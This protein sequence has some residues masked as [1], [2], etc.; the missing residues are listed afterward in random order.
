MAKRPKAQE[1]GAALWF[2]SYGDVITNMLCFF[3]MLFSFS[4]LDTPKKRQE[5]EK[6]G[7]KY[8]A[9]FSLY[10]DTGAS[11]WL[12]K[13]DKGIALT[14]S[15]Q[16]NPTPRLIRKVRKVLQTVPAREK[17]QL[18]SDDSMVK[19]R[20]PRKVLFESGS[21]KMVPGGEEILQAL[22]SLI[23]EIPHE[24]RIDGHTDEEPIERDKYPSHWELSAARACTVVRYFTTRIGMDAKRFSAQG[25]A[26]TQP[27]VPGTSEANKEINRRIELNIMLRKRQEKATFKWD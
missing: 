23:Y 21:T 18:L 2:V 1:A 26:D 8:W 7:E 6:R 19:V 24:I 17:L 16:I 20:I 13:G 9:A 22:V 5:A 25:F 14:P 12:T 3:V 10:R 15:N 27:R 4:N 11:Q